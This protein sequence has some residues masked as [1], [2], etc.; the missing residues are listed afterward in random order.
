MSE[1]SPIPQSPSLPIVQRVERESEKKQE[2]TKRQPK[3]DSPAEL[4]PSQDDQ[5]IQHID[6]IV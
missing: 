2:N 1:I 5:S 4:I 3:R 6:E